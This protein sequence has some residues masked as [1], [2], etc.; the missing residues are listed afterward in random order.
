MKRKT[1]KGLSGIFSKFNIQIITSY[2]PQDLIYNV[3][4]YNKKIQSFLDISLYTY[5][6]QFIKNKV[7]I[8]F[9][10][11]SISDL[12]CFL[13]SEFNNFNKK[14]DEK[15]LEKITEEIISEKETETLKFPT[16]YDETIRG[17]KKVN[18]DKYKNDK[19]TVMLDLI[20]ENHLDDDN[21][22]E[23]ENENEDINKNKQQ[24]K[25]PSGIFPNLKGLKVSTIYILPVSMIMKLD[26][27]LIKYKPEYNLL[28]YNDIDQYEID[29]N[30]KYLEIQNFETIS[31]DEDDIHETR[32]NK[33][34]IINNK[35]NKVKFN[36]LNLEYLDIQINPEVD[37]SLLLYYFNLDFMCAAFKHLQKKLNKIKLYLD[38]KETILSLNFMPSLKHFRFSPY[39]EIEDETIIPVFKMQ[40]CKNGLKTFS[41]AIGSQK[42]SF[43]T[44]SLIEKYEENEKNE[45]VL[46]KYKNTGFLNDVQ[47][48]SIKNLNSIMIVNDKNREGKKIELQKIR[49]LF[50]LEENNYSVEEIQ[51]QLN[52]MEVKLIDNISKFKVL[53]K[54]ILFAPIK[55]KKILFQF[56]ED[57]S[58]LGWLNEFNIIFEGKLSDEEE[59]LIQ[60]LLPDASIY[61]KYE[62]SKTIY[63]R[64]NYEFEYFYIDPEDCSL[65]YN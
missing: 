29:I 5:Q 11:I 4:K 6:K 57:I 2:I 35:E 45:F 26:Y 41:F 24:M 54:L 20:D 50:N 64:Q 25:I 40:K 42:G 43:E 1:K 47:N 3:V 56:L 18:W 10:E 44:I 61:K 16:N 8:D 34:I 17:G 12:H 59:G 48:V 28:F 15:I 39:I 63:I 51:L 60:E 37:Y 36:L 21:D 38:L 9:E 22:N 31:D 13:K 7:L 65:I 19:K 46:K 58:N 62:S 30:L 14:G 53:Q 55:Q 27:L 52:Y 23:D 32:N 49:S 33:N